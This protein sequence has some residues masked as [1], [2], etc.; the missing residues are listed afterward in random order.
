MEQRRLKVLIDTH[1][2]LD[3]I[4]PDERPSSDASATIFKVIKEGFLEGELSTQSIIDAAYIAS[5]TEGKM[6]EGFRS[7][8]LELSTFVNIDSMDFPSVMKAVKNCTGDFEDDAQ[9]A[10]AYYTGC[11][12]VLTGDKDFHARCGSKSPYIRFFSP[13]DFLAQLTS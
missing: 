7:K 9:F 4:C 11:D 13:K 5:Q 10:F 6:V 8:I 2:L 1:V 12:I 3:V